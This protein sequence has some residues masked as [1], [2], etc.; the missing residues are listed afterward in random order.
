M[1]TRNASEIGQLIRETRNQQ[2]LSQRELASR[3]G[4]HQPKISEIERGKAT[5]HIG[6]VL[7]ILSALD[8]DVH[9]GSGPTGSD[10]HQQLIDEPDYD[11]SID[12]D[13]IA[14]TGLKK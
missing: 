7:R 1:L 8:L 12:L 13:A 14:D 2:K 9:I 4:V 11:D 6:I 3:A 5:A 10:T